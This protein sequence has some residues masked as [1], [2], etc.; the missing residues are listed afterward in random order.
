MTHSF[1][2]TQ[3]IN[4]L[5]HSQASGGLNVTAP[6]SANVAQPGDYMLFVLNGNGVPSV[7]KIVRLRP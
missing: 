1:N 5:A 4:V 3:R 6:S 2:E 7:A